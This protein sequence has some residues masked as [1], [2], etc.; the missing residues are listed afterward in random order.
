MNCIHDHVGIGLA[1][2]RRQT[3][4]VAT[5][6]SKFIHLII[7]SC[8][9]FLQPDCMTTCLI[10]RW[11]NSDRPGATSSDDGSARGLCRHD[12][13]CYSCVSSSTNVQSTV[14][15]TADVHQRERKFVS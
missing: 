3:A 7:K 9:Y 10:I 4:N 12:H 2:C 6:C 1:H 5:G 8:V 15:S 14:C 11:I 13:G